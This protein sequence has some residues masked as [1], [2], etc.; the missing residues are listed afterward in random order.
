MDELLAWREF[1]VAVAGAAAALTGLVYVGVSI[2]AGRRRERLGAVAGRCGS[3]DRRDV[4]AR[5]SVRHDAAT[6]LGSD[7]RA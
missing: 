6:R 3:V 4:R 7:R 5:W 1:Y 2:Q